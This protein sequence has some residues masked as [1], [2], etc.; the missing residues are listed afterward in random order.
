LLLAS[1]AAG[2]APGESERP[3]D[4]EVFIR[5][6]CPRCAD[7]ERFLAELQR[8]RPQLAVAFSHVDRDP[9]ALRRLR[10]LAERRGVRAI[11]LP[12]FH[13][14]DTLV[15]GFSSAGDTG[16]RITALLAGSASSPQRAEPACP[17]DDPEFCGT[18]EEVER[19]NVPLIGAIATRDLDLPLFTIVL[20]LLDGFNP[21]AMWVLLFL[22]SLL[23]NV[24]SRARMLAVAGTF[25][26]A[27]GLVYFAF[28]AAWLNVFLLIGFSTLARIVLGLVAF[29]VGLANVKDFFAFG[30]GISFGI[31]EGVKP[32]LYARVRRV[33]QAE[34]LTGAA[35]GVIV[36]AVLANTVELLCTA[37]LPAVYTHVLALR[38]LPG[39]AYYAYL[40]LYNAAYM[41]D[42]AVM[43]LIAVITLERY[44]LQ[45]RAGRWLKLVSGVVLLALG[46]ALLLRPE[47]LAFDA[48]HPSAGSPVGAAHPSTPLGVSGDE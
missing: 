43:V 6:G 11:G 30:H 44:K 39:W 45:E 14:R 7:A 24:R 2:P 20:G 1:V 37:G 10:E 18:A 17:P 25:V 3:P 38:K 41:L 28:M 22:L 4:I 8:E 27:S 46:L 33:L 42:D 23:V 40:G 32:R 12:A 15:I 29:G 47:W 35:A 5:A 13:V 16:A 36:L 9:S 21:C 48:D 26:V 34:N 19:V 31:P